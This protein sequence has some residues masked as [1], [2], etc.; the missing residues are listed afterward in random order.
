VERET[1]QPMPSPG[2]DRGVRPSHGR[3]GAPYWRQ[4]GIIVLAWVVSLVVTDVWG[5]AWWWGVI[6][7]LVVGTPLL[8]QQWMAQRE[9][10]RSI[11]HGK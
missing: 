4:T 7:A 2:P 10:G 3:L 1:Y 8:I 11:D 5:L 6:A 9:P